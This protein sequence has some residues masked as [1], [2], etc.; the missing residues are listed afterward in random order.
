MSNPDQPGA[1]SKNSLPTA[2]KIAIAATGLLLIFG[3]GNALT[4][5]DPGPI[6]N[7]LPI[8]TDTPSTPADAP[9]TSLNPDSATATPTPHPT[10][11][12]PTFTYPGDP[13]CAITYRDNG[14]GSMAWIATTTVNGELITHAS[15][16]DGNI[17]RHD[18]HITRGPNAFRAPVPLSQINDIGGNL[19]ADDGS[20]YGCSVQPGSQ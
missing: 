13:Q 11:P 12:L 15:T 18:E 16:T 7:S 1:P 3:V 2:G 6:T 5:S 20:S 19:R 8:A 9:S 10:A 14:D 4:S 17:Y